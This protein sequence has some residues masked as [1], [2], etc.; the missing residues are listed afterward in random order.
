MPEAPE[1]APETFPDYDKPA[2]DD[3]GNPIL[4]AD[5]FPFANPKPTLKEKLSKVAAHCAYVR[6]DGVN[7]FHKYNYATA[8]T[9]FE[10]V[11]EA[12][13]EH[14]LIS[15]PMFDLA[16]EKERTNAKG[17]TEHLVIVECNL[18]V[19]D[20]DSKDDIKCR[21]FGSG[22]DNGDKAV[23]KA[24]TAALKYAWMMLLNISTGDDPEDDAKVD[25]RMSGEPI[26]KKK[27]PEEYQA[28]VEA[29]KAAKYSPLAVELSNQINEALKAPQ[30]PPK[31]LWPGDEQEACKCGSRLLTKTTSNE[32]GSKPYQTCELSD[33]AFRKDFEAEATMQELEASG[34]CGLK[35]HTWKWVK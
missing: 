22:Q 21:A 13:I 3:A 7:L 33:K 4:V 14:R 20:L 5:V 32:K 23:M 28:T 18:Y 35:E 17:G 29:N 27:T 1:L 8:A 25:S 19:Q 9:I 31:G 10:K 34:V 11:N 30:A 2:L 6:K 24:Q 12:L 15:Q 16:S 26:T